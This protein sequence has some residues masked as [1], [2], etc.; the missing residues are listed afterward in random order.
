MRRIATAAVANFLAVAGAGLL[1]AWTYPPPPKATRR[2]PF[3][4][5]SHEDAQS[6]SPRPDFAGWGGGTRMNLTLLAC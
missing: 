3:A 2:T 1:L 6:R 5:G 4:G